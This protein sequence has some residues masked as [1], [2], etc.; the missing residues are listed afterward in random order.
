MK[1]F[2][3]NIVDDLESNVDASIRYALTMFDASVDTKFHLGENNNSTMPADFKNY[4]TNLGKDGGNTC[5]GEYPK[6]RR[7]RKNDK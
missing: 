5:T 2:I 3:K 4:I 6:S 1:T 7:N